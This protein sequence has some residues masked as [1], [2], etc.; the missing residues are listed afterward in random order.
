MPKIST[1]LAIAFSIHI[2]ILIIYSISFGIKKSSQSKILN[3]QNTINIGFSSAK[4][5][6]SPKVFQTASQSM[7]S[8]PSRVD[9]LSKNRAH[10]ANESL[11]PISTSHRDGE[12]GGEVIYDFESTAMSYREPVYPRLAIKRELQGSI[13]VRIKVSIDGKPNNV[14]ILKS[15]GHEL[16]DNA[17]LEAVAYWQFQSIASTYFVEKTVVFKINN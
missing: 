3:T 14:E 2:L 10:D 6:I 12:G 5:G 17:V 11:N 16:L 4:K 15:S 1:S 7:S 13:K 9:V 8:A